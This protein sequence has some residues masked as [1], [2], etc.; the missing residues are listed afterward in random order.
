MG[1]VLESLLW[2]SIHSMSSNPVFNSNKQIF[3][4]STSLLPGSLSWPSTWEWMRRALLFTTTLQ[5]YLP[6]K[7]LHSVCIFCP[8]I[9]LLLSPECLYGPVSECSS[10]CQGAFMC[11]HNRNYVWV[12]NPSS[13]CSSGGLILVCV[14]ERGRGNEDVFLELGFEGLLLIVTTI[15]LT[16]L[17]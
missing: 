1:K 15:I 12:L 16:L 5:I 2:L 7:Y 9:C 6:N 4:S 17:P 3:F 11:V 10:D 14:G 13:M 8:V